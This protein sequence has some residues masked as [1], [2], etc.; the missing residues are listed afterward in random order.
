MHN[1]LLIFWGTLL[2]GYIQIIC[3]FNYLCIFVCLN[4]KAFSSSFSLFL[5]ISLLCLFLWLFYVFIWKITGCFFPVHC[6]ASNT[7][8]FHF[9]LCI[10]MRMKSTFVRCV[11]FFTDVSFLVAI[12]RVFDHFNWTDSNSTTIWWFNSQ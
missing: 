1:T 10:F 2:F 6:I 5:S 12:W 11:Q 3:L 9:L 8:L 7:V 4:G